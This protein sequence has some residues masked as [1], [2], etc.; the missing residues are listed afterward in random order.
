[1]NTQTKV[2]IGILGAVVVGLGVALGVVLANDGGD[3][4]RANQRMMNSDDS[5]TSMMG[6]MGSMD[7]DAMLGRMHDALGDGQYQRMLD[8]FREHRS[9]AS[10]TGADAAIDKMMHEMMDSMMQ[11]MPMDSGNM[12]PG[13]RLTPQRTLVPSPS[14]EHH[15]TPRP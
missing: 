1:M 3:S 6:A 11:R 15:E 7:S 2:L 13:N 5:F 4:S 12:M 8:H 14:D 10:T 9:G